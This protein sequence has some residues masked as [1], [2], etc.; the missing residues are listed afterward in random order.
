MEHIITRDMLKGSIDDFKRLISMN[1]K[2]S[3]VI[4][5][6]DCMFETLERDIRCYGDEMF[7]IGYRAGREEKI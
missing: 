3:E 1:F 7:E 2:D 4:D 6:F 5:Q